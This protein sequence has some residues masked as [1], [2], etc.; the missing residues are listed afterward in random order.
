MRKL[1][2]EV[3]IK[4]DKNITTKASGSQVEVT[5]NKNIAVDSVKAGDT[6]INDN[7]LTISNGPSVTK[8][9]IDVAD[10][11]ISN[12]ADGVLD[13]NSKDAVNG[14]QLHEVKELASKGWNATATKKEG[15]TGE[16]TGTEVANVASGQTV[17]YIAGDNIKLEQNGINFTIST[18]KDLKAGN[19]TADK[20][21]A[22]NTVIEGNRVAINNGSR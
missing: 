21:T 18:T 8:T 22:G 15:S 5:L 10:N 1:D 9:G 11:K 7:G 4:G 19:V 17:N 14:S 12:V 6:I 20:F 3:A 2:D 16:V 13:A